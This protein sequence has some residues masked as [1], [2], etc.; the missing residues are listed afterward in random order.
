MKRLILICLFAVVTAAC[1]GNESVAP[2]KSSNQTASAPQASPLNPAEAVQF[3]APKMQ[4][5]AGDSGEAILKLKIQ[6][7]FHINANPPSE[8]YLIPTTVEF[9]SNNGLTFEKPSYPAGESKKFEFSEK[10]LAVYEGEI[11]IK[12]PVK[13]EAKVSKGEQNVNGKLR[14][15]ACDEAVCYRPQTVDVVIPIDIS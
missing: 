3:S 13:V 5:K 8:N 9:E 2:Q 6:P 12:L 14:F 7:P 11:E 10:P 1:A 15:Q 4:I